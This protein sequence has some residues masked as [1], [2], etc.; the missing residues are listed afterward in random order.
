MSRLY[1]WINSD[2][3]KIAK[4]ITGHEYLEITVNW[5]SRDNSKRAAYLSVTWLKDED[6]PTVRLI[7]GVGS[8]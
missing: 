5:G 4:T 8:E 6:Q 7:N 2:T 1:A 3:N